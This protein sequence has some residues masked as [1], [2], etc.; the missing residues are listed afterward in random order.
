[1]EIMIVYFGQGR[2]TWAMTWKRR[3][4]HLIRKFPPILSLPEQSW[5]RQMTKTKKIK[6]LCISE[7]VKLS[8]MRPLLKS[9]RNWSFSANGGRTKG[10]SRIRRDVRAKT[11]QRPEAKAPRETRTCSK[12]TLAN[13]D[14]SPLG[15]GTWDSVNTVINDYFKGD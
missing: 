11:S 15:S 1:M 14:A 7:N 5:G 12:H 2:R 3:K 8:W 9:K 10:E 6:K 4:E 13:S